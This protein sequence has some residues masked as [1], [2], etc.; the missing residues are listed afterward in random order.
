MPALWQ[1][2]HP[3]EL[4]I[5]TWTPIQTPIVGKVQT[6]LPRL[7]V[8]DGDWFLISR[9]PC[10]IR[11]Y[12]K[13]GGDPAKAIVHHQ[14]ND[15]GIINPLWDETYLIKWIAQLREWGISKTTQPDFSTWTDLAVVTQLHNFYR[16]CCVSRDFS[17][18]GIEVI[19]I[20]YH[21]NPTIGPLQSKCLMRKASCL[22]VDGQH[23]YTGI[24]PATNVM[25]LI[26]KSMRSADQT[27]VPTVLVMARTSKIGMRAKQFCP[28]AQ[29]VMSRTAVRNEIH[30]KIKELRDH[31]EKEAGIVRAKVVRQRKKKETGTPT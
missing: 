31:A 18:G 20:A 24:G 11:E 3:G 5:P 28:R 21:D 23:W 16:S 17:L 19:P 30:N 27:G 4:G 1:E 29:W 6:W 15:V 10:E 25:T 13:K 14:G 26:G 2:V 8:T 22:L 12:L 9:I 7:S